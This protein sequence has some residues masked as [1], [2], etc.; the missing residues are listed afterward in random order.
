MATHLDDEED[1][2]RLKTWW[3]ENWVALVGGLV[4]GF[5]AIGGWEGYKH[6][7]DGRSQTA[8]QMYEELRKHL[9]ANRAED[10]DQIM[11]RLKAE[12]A[13]TPYAAAAALASAQ[14]EVR[15]ARLDAAAANLAWVVE[16]ADDKGLAQLARLRQAR[17]LLAQGRHDEAQKVLSAEPGSFASLY[18]EL[19]GDIALA[20]G[21]HEAARSA[22]ARALAA[23]DSG[24]INKTLLQQKLD[25]LAPVN[26]S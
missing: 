5:G 10:A 12:F 22:Y 19:R 26:P 8:S 18:E 15:G 13:S 9:D 25:D 17:V 7:R 11:A 20:K 24:A 1:L 3:R 23:A 16:H 4:I 2:E 14:V 6:W 21:E